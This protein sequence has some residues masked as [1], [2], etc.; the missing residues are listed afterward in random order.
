[1]S[2]TVLVTSSA[3]SFTLKLPPLQLFRSC[4]VCCSE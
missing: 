2:E 4:V 1:L 3:I